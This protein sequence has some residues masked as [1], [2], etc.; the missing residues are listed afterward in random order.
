MWVGDFAGFPASLPANLLMSSNVEK[1]DLF[2]RYFEDEDHSRGVAEQDSLLS[3]MRTSQR[4]EPEARGERIV[5][6][7]LDQIFKLGQK[8]WVL[9]EEDPRRP[10]KGT[11][12][13]SCVT[14]PPTF[15]ASSTVYFPGRAVTG[16]GAVPIGLALP[17]K[18]TL[19]W[20]S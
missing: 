7:L 17:P 13:A 5:H 15:R 16:A 9:P 1:I 10:E 8:V 6:E 19:P 11:G 20:I 2:F 12:P 18:F 3:S 14:T 4:V